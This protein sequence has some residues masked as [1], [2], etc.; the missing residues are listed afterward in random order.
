MQKFPADPEHQVTLANWRQSPFNQWAFH[1]VREIVPSADIANDPDNVWHLEENPV[2][3]GGVSIDCEDE[4]LMSLSGFC[5]YAQVDALLVLHRDKIVYEHYHQGMTRY[6]PH[7]LMSVSKS[8]LGVVAG[9]LADKNILDVDAQVTA[10]IPELSDSAYQGA[11]V[12]HLLDMRTGVEFDEDYLA[13]SGPIIDY[14]KSTN[15]N[16]PDAEDSPTDLRSFLQR[17]TERKHDHGLQFSYASTNTDL[18]GWVIERASGQSYASVIQ[19]HLWQ[20]MGAEYS[21]YVTVDRLGAPRAAGGVCTTLRDLA[22]VARLI[23][24]GGKGQGGKPVIA[25]E[26]IRD[27]L[28]NGDRDA[29][30][31]GNFAADFPQLP[32]SYRSQWYVLHPRPE[33]DASWL[34]A[35]GIHGQNIYI[36]IDNEFVMIKFASHSL[37]LDPSSG[38]HGIVAAKAV[39]DY[40]VNHF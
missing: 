37:P 35:L 6:S 20:P 38:I 13:T 5:H 16:P 36:D 24:K 10:Y 23:T 8:L 12:R 22:R 18:L 26:W 40:L 3:L 14:R 27:T 21:G 9:I 2:N 7:I 34:V 1:H 31:N 29:W 4:G 25:E 39:R 15:W 11:T 28:Q 30:N 17:L 33:D 32:M 19:E